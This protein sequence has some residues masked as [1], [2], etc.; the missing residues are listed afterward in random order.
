MIT[1]ETFRM[2]FAATLLFGVVLCA[3]SARAANVALL[4]DPVFV[5]EAQEAVRLQSAIVGLGHTVTTINGITPAQWRTALDTADVLVFPELDGDLS[6]SLA[7][8]AKSEIANFVLSGGGLIS[9]GSTSFTATLVNQLFGWA[10]TPTFP[11]GSSSLNVTAA[12]GTPF[13]GGTLALTNPSL[14]DGMT[15]GT[16]PP[17]SLPIY[18]VGGSSTVLATTVGAT[19]RYVFL[20]FDWFEI[21]TP[22]DWISV[23]GSAI[24]FATGGSAEVETI[25]YFNDPLYIDTDTEGA[26]LAAALDGIGQ[27][28]IEFT[29]ITGAEW[30]AATR[31]ADVLVIPEMELGNL[32]VDLPSDARAAITEFVLS[33]GGLILNDSASMQVFLL[34]GLFGFS[35]VEGSTG[36]ASSINLA[37]AAGTAFSTAPPTLP[38]A[39]AVEGFTSASLPAGSKNLFTVGANSVVFAVDRGWGRIVSL[40]FDWFSEPTPLPWLVALSCAVQHAGLGPPAVSVPPTTNAGA[41]AIVTADLSGFVGLSSANLRFRAGGD[42]TFQSTLLTQ[43]GPLA[44][45]ATIPAA[46]VSG[47]G[48]QYFVEAFGGGAQV[49]FAPLRAPASHWFSLP[50][51]VS[52]FQVASLGASTY[53]LSGI[54]VRADDVNPVAVFD[55]LGDYNVK[56]WRYGTF[57]SSINDYREPPA[58]FPSAPGQG[59][60]IIA[61]DAKNIAVT[62][63]STDLS[64]NLSVTLRPGWNQIAN[65]FGFST[66]FADLV[67][68]AGVESNLI[69]FNGSYVT[70]VQTLTPGAG[71]WIRNGNTSS[72]V[73]EF[74]P[75]GAGVAAKTFANSLGVIPDE[76][77]GW[78]LRVEARAGEESDH[79]NWLGMRSAAADGVDDLDRSDPPAQP[80]NWVSLS[81]APE[82]GRALLADWRANGVENGGRWRVVFASDQSGEPFHVNFVP[83]GELPEG[84]SIAAF[85]GAREIDLSNS[86]RIEGRVPSN[87]HEIVWDV[88]VGDA[89]YLERVRD[90]QL[91]Q[92]TEVALGAPFPNPSRTGFALDFATPRPTAA[93]VEVF[94]VRGRLVTTLV[95]GQLDPGVHRIEWNGELAHGKRAAA[96][97][98]FIRSKAND[99]TEN[100]KVVLLQ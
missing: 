79:E 17:G 60:W 52:G 86:S 72:S 84:W 98:Y 69:G 13:E 75:L 6:A 55:E 41:D 46:Q 7:D 23:L 88:V 42:A 43:T 10:L 58:A 100:R 25:A 48:V 15:T 27:N 65:P 71:Y 49:G 99:R 54:Q 9:N 78:S 64:Q 76:E 2:R 12:A 95:N 40:G 56:E 91:S 90:G 24:T 66:D 92:I 26:L 51:R 85:D 16:G 1:R 93:L 8:S 68:P 80:E 81:F 53:Q 73:I 61:K 67:L 3:G 57:D 18:F 70:N 29:G 62:A 87:G 33:G 44:W 50:V 45:T 5:D 94:D 97:V 11:S 96:G 74:P 59:F 22:L 82:D 37:A 30:R 38:D 83:E 77:T 35:L 39:S 20:G 28:R 21:P 47:K 89:K 14:V 31:D 32:F 34:N 63:T 36:V 19:G 4:F